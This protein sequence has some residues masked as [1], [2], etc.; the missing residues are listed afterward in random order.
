MLSRP[1]RLSGTIKLIRLAKTPQALN[2]RFTISISASGVVAD[3]ILKW[4]LLPEMAANR[5][6][7]RAQD[8]ADSS[9]VVATCVCTCAL[10]R[11]Q[12]CSQLVGTLAVINDAYSN[13]TIPEWNI[14][15]LYFVTG[16]VAQ[17][18]KNIDVKDAEGLFERLR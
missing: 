17:E 15:Q 16:G 5:T 12:R 10:L 11:P 2:L 3:V 7:S 4:L 14:Q 18:N 1:R 8:E 6:R 13:G 9:K